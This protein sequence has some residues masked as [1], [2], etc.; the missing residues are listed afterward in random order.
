MSVII[1]RE[2]MHGSRRP[3]GSLLLSIRCLMRFA[4]DAIITSDCVLHALD[5]V[6]YIIVYKALHIYEH[7]HAVL[8][9]CIYL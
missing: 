9:S 6:Y 4:P 7:M 5:H 1:Y 8:V 3:I 2:C